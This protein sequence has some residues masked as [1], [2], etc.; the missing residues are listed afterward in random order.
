M[1]VKKG[2][3]GPKGI[4]IATKKDGV[5]KKVRKDPRD[6][7]KKGSARGIVEKKEKRACSSARGTFFLGS[8]H[9]P[10][11]KHGGD[12]QKQPRWKKPERFST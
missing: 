1:G 11:G 4:P 7:R 3:R 5:G 8:E 10:V 6:A 9:K 2:R 12:R